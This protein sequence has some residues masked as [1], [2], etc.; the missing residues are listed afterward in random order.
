MIDRSQLG[1]PIDVRG[2]FPRERSALLDLLGELAA[3]DWE[4]ATVCPGWTVKDVT[5]HVLH[6]DLRRLASMRD[7]QQGPRPEPGEPVA[8]FLDRVNQEWVAA[9]RC[10]SSRQLVELLTLNGGQIAALWRALDPDTGGA[11]VSWAGLEVAPVWLD[12]ARELSEYWTH[13]QQ[14]RE[15][16]GRPGLTD[17]Q[18][19][20]PVLDTF[21]RALPYTLRDT[22]AD[23]GTQVQVT[24]SGP[25]PMRWVATRE[26]TGWVLRRGDAGRPA[27]TVELDGDTLWRLCTRNITPEDAAARARVHGERRLAEQVLRIVSIVY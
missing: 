6:D 20:A 18:L 8:A 22:G 4:R 21:L 27:A 25:A 13:Q 1:P 15:A 23:P 2:L 26:D 19:L 17:R 12:A 11:A 5:A 10:L 9:T 16:T 3:G 24:V 14:I 7:G